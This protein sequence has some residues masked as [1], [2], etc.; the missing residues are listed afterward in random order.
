M[1]IC[2]VAATSRR[3]G[4]QP[5]E[6]TRRIGTSVFTIIGF[7]G[8]A[9]VVLQPVQ[10]FESSLSQGLPCHSPEL[11]HLTPC[12]EFDDMGEVI[13]NGL[14]HWAPGVELG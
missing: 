5:M 12:L 14:Q 3:E 10:A 6:K 8:T 9:I 11:D 2:V 4:I 7:I 1:A 13:M